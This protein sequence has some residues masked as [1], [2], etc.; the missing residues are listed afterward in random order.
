MPLEEALK[1]A[2]LYRTVCVPFPSR[3]AHECLRISSVL[4]SLVFEGL[5]LSLKDCRC[6]AKV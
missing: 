4:K 1:H 2:I 5:Q 3:S 6:L